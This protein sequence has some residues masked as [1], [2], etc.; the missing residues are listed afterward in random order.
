MQQ[1]TSSMHSSPDCVSALFLC[2]G[3]LGIWLQPGLVALDCAEPHLLRYSAD[4][5][6]GQAHVVSTT[7]TTNPAQTPKRQTVQAGERAVDSADTTST[8]VQMARPMWSAQPTRPTLRKIKHSGQHNLVDVPASAT[9][10]CA[11]M[12]RP[13]WSARP[14]RP[15]LPG[16]N[17]C[18]VAVLCK[19]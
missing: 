5:A 19:P 9:V 4:K 14:T 7:H 15:T 17:A 10:T 13:M 16:C 8:C 1:P 2:P 12:A 11:Q 18:T 3:V 6:D